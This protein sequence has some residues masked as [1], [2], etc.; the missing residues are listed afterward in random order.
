MLNEFVQLLTKGGQNS[1]ILTIWTTRQLL[2]TQHMYVQPNMIPMDGI[3]WNF[4][5]SVKDENPPFFGYLVLENV[6]N[7]L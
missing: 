2:F 4:I 5:K 7:K 6:L 1:I 3:S